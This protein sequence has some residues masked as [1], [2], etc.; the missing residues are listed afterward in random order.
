MYCRWNIATSHIGKILKIP[1]KISCMKYFLASEKSYSLVTVK[2]V[3]KSK[4]NT[5]HIFIFWLKRTLVALINSYLCQLIYRED[6]PIAKW[7]ISVAM[8]NLVFLVENKHAPWNAI[9]SFRETCPCW[10]FLSLKG[11]I[12]SFLMMYYT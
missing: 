9:K 4:R 8:G 5:S 3:E 6:Y 2:N 11:E 7:K 12:L 1:R 10:F